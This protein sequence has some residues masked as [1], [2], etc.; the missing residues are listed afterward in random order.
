MALKRQNTTTTTNKKTNLRDAF[1]KMHRHYTWNKNYK[2]TS[3]FNPPSQNTALSACFNFIFPIRFIENTLADLWVN[4]AESRRMGSKGGMAA[5]C[6][7]SYFPGLC[8]QALPAWGLPMQHPL[9]MYPGPPWQRI[10][11]AG[12]AASLVSHKA[13]WPP[14]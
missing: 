1:N 8:T 7:C 11:D 12:T 10:H 13:L 3:N 4:L 6:N 14:F 2:S 5:S 9:W